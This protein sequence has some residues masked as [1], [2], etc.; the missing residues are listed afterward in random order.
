MPAAGSAYLGSFVDPSGNSLRSGNP[1]GGIAS[2]SSELTAL[3]VVQQTLARPL[4]I[5]PVYLN[6][7]DPITVTELDQVIA[8]GGIPMIT[9]SCGAKDTNVIAGRDDSQINLVAAKLAQ[10][11]LPVFLRWFP[12]PNVNTASNACLGSS[13]A[14][15]YVAAY[16]HIHDELVAAGASNV[17]FVWSVDTTTPQ[18][19]RSWSSYYPGSQYVDWIG[20]DGYATS[21]A[22]ES[23]ANDFGR[24]M[25]TFPPRSRS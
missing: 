7:N 22:T 12:D 16:R 5:V 15:G 19:S 18:A 21:S 23:V 2:L 8:T 3:P 10:F 11:R 25:R 4:S 17:I 13:G 20:A 1:T 14:T 6:W 9:W 24:G